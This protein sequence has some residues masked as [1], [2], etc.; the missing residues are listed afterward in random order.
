MV[1]IPGCRGASFSGEGLRRL[2]SC[3]VFVVYVRLDSFV[4]LGFLWNLVK[5]LSLV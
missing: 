1:L 2:L 3:F 5:G 4:L